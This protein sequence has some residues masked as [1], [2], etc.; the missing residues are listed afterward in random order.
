[1]QGAKDVVSEEAGEAEQRGRPLE[2]AVDPMAS[3]VLVLER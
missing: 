3:F 1:M 2:C